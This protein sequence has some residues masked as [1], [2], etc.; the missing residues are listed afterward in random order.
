MKVRALGGS[1]TIGHKWCMNQLLRGGGEW[2]PYNLDKDDGKSSDHR[3]KTQ[4]GDKESEK[5]N[6]ASL[7]EKKKTGFGRMTL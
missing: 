3:S 6:R 1:D 7:K 5:G 4:N 2:N